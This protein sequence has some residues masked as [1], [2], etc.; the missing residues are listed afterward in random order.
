MTRDHA[1]PRKD[2]KLRKRVK[3]LMEEI[4]MSQEQT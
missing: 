3:E 4:N 1:C 2:G